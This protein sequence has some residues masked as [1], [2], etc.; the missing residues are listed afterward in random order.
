MCWA[1]LG[2]DGGGQS[3]PSL[4]VCRK[5]PGWDN[6]EEGEEWGGCRGRL[7]RGSVQGVERWEGKRLRGGGGYRL[8]QPQPNTTGWVTLSPSAP[9]WP[10]FPMTKKG[11]G[12]LE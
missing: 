7:V 2:R 5:K 9:P 6:S 8:Q 12:L 11:E 1:V 10:P 3:L 4:S